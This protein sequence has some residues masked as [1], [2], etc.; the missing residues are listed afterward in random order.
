MLAAAAIM[1]GACGAAEAIREARQA[2]Q[3]LTGLS[4]DLASE[5]SR[6]RANLG[7]GG[8]AN[9]GTGGG[10]SGGP[11]PAPASFNPNQTSGGETVVGCCG[12]RAEADQVGV[13]DPASLKAYALSDDARL[14]LENWGGSFANTSRNEGELARKQAS[15]FSM[16][17]DD[18]TWV[19]E[20][21]QAVIELRRG[22]VRAGEFVK[23]GIPGRTSWENR[24]PSSTHVSFLPYGAA[25][26][27][28][29]RT[30]QHPASLASRTAI[31]YRGI[32]EHSQFLLMGITDSYGL[33]SENSNINPL[34]RE[35]IIS[36][37]A[38]LSMGAPTPAS[39]W[40]TSLTGTW[41]GRGVSFAST[42]SFVSGPSL[43]SGPYSLNVGPGYTRFITQRGIR[44][45]AINNTSLH[46]VDVTLR[47]DGSQQR[48][49][50]GFD[51][52][53]GELGRINSRRHGAGL[54]AINHD[55]GHAPADSST[56]GGAAARTEFRN[57]RVHA[58]TSGAVLFHKDDSSS[59]HAT[60]VR[61]DRTLSDETPET[62]NDVY[63]FD[64]FG[65]FYGPAGIEIGG[66]FTLDEKRGHSRY[67]PNREFTRHYRGA[68]GAK[69]QDQ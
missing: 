65:G 34:N 26:E 54:A 14:S 2:I 42:S 11:G 24:H 10:G 67:D 48:I 32:L 33:L 29:R 66:T 44:R 49:D 47:L 68:F 3:D 22:D 30:G 9:P 5:I 1:L 8:G 23:Q 38:A 53:Q 21:P 61:I 59:L 19:S 64:V 35:S 46:N 41:R 36:Q 62:I 6:A 40:D 25:V 31:A 20:D 43:R 56:P 50:L 27:F 58:D 12:F 63:E 55:I 69:K 45:N 15:S 52:G 17:Y 16:K 37:S 57:L 18:F 39:N 28:A 51:R 4:Q 7:T 13:G 60:Y